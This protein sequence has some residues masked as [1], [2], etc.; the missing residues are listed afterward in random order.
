MLAAIAL[1]SGFGGS[2][3]DDLIALAVGAEHGNE[4][5]DILLV[6]RVPSWH[7]SGSKSTSETLPE[8]D[9]TLPVL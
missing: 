7:T 4:H 3:L 5:H 2:A 1:F 8:K 6:K 9:T